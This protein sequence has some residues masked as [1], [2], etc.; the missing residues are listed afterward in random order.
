MVERI[1][2]LFGVGPS[3]VITSLIEDSS[4]SFDSVMTVVFAA[5]GIRR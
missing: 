4:S 5:P 3:S 1:S 2:R